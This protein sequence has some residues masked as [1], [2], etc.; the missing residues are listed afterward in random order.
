MV[1][2]GI[3]LT[4]KWVPIKAADRAAPQEAVTPNMAAPQEVV[5]LV[6]V[7]VVMK[8]GEGG[9]LD[10]NRRERVIVMLVNQPGAVAVDLTA[11]RG[12]LLLLYHG[13]K[14]TNRHCLLVPHNLFL[15]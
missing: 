2:T 4:L 3:Q 1:S 8:G 10:L 13:L 15:V 9:S 7:V 14:F 5:T 11:G 6:V 12:D